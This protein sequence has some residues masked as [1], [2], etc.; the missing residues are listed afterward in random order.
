LLSIY[1]PIFFVLYLG[2]WLCLYASNDNI[3]TI[4]YRFIFASVFGGYSQSGNQ[5]I[6]STLEQVLFLT[7]FGW[8]FLQVFH[9]GMAY[10]TLTVSC[11]KSH[12]LNTGDIALSEQYMAKAIAAVP[13]DVYYRA[14]SEIQL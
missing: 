12:M 10:K 8:F 7:Y 3:D 5:S 2:L 4:L 14:L 1:D 13:N 11:F 6:F 9:L